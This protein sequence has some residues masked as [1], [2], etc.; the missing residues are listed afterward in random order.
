M[1][2]KSFKTGLSLA[3]GNA[4]AAIPNAPTIGTA[5]KTG[6]TSAT[7]TY[8]AASLGALG[9]TFT[10]TS[11]PGSVTGTG[12]SPITVSG[13][14]GG[15]NYTFTVKATNANGDSPASSAS[16][17]ITTDQDIFSIDY[18]VVAGGGGGGNGAQSLDNGGGGGAGGYRTSI[19]S[20]TL[21]LS[22]ST[23]YSVTV[24]AGGAAGSASGTNST[25]ASIT[26]SGGGK[27]GGSG[28]VR[29]L[30]GGSGG[31]GGQTNNSNIP[32][33]GNAG[34]Y[35][36]VEGYSGS[37]RDGYWAGGG[38]GA[39]AVGTAAGGGGAGRFNV[40]SND[41]QAGEVSGGNYYLAGGG[42]GGFNSYADRKGLPGL[43]GG[44]NG[45]D[46]AGQWFGSAQAG[47]ANTGG[48]GGGGASQGG[49]V[50]GANGGSGIVILKY[51]D[52]KTITIGAG[53]TGT[54]SA[55]SGGYKRAK[56]TAGTGNVSWA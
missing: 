44:G 18:L 9:T 26:S 17:Q 7:V 13:L 30:S 12:S 16:N 34:S 23:N 14:T 22:P 42:G 49:S 10:A 54:E 2:T 32:G 51:P 28:T 52:T 37:D 5:T 46:Y 47:T 1:T 4:S 39:S 45:S 27:G 33:T 29:A 36:P 40:L 24:G 53:L 35:S 48:G 21:S 56:I 6:A 50:P 11:N 38:G 25:F 15:T 31:G 43:G 20:S 19:D 3:V 55:A 41:V 8:T